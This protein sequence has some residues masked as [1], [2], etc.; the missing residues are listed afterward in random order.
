MRTSDKE[1]GRTLQKLDVHD[2]KKI[3]GG[4]KILL[5][6]KE[7]IGTDNEVAIRGYWT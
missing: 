6:G 7:E 5:H 2:S 3:H 1:P 4:K